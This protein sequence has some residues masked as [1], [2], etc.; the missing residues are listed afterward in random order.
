MKNN[1]SNFAFSKHLARPALALIAL[2][3]LNLGLAP[4]AFAGQACEEKPQTPL[5]MRNAFALAAQTRI[6]IP[7][8]EELVFI[9]RV[10]SDLSKYGLRFS[11]LGIAWR[12]N[13]KGSWLVTHL[14]NRCGTAESSLY[15]EGLANFFAD[16]MFAWESVVMLPE[17]PLQAEIVKILENETAMKLHHKRYNLLAY[18]FSTQY[19]NSNQWVL[20]VLAMANSK[21]VTDRSSAQAWLKTA[22]YLPTTLKID[23]LTRL[24]ARMTK[25]NVAF[26]DHPN[27]RRFADAI[28]VVSVESVFDFM[29]KKSMVGGVYPAKLDLAFTQGKAKPAPPPP[30]PL[31]ANNEAAATQLGVEPNTRKQTDEEL[32]RAAEF[33]RAMDERHALNEARGEVVTQ[34]RESIKN[35]DLVAGLDHLDKGK[36]FFTSAV[37]WQEILLLEW[38]MPLTRLCRQPD[39][40]PQTPPAPVCVQASRKLTDIMLATMQR[41]PKH[42]LTYAGTLI[43]ASTFSGDTAFYAKFARQAIDSVKKQMLTGDGFLEI[44]Q[45]QI[46]KIEPTQPDAVLGRWIL[47]KSPYSAR[48]LQVAKIRNEDLKRLQT[49]APASDAVVAYFQAN[50]PDSAMNAVLMKE[51]HSSGVGPAQ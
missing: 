41:F 46:P 24:G 17:R 40:T 47:E 2:L 23:A 16:D 34:W 14:L 25:A 39:G 30:D 1:Y 33:Q 19:Q 22:G 7:Q 48:R 8:D 5:R 3:A 37:Q 18:P 26:D 21:Q 50:F 12:E 29:Q 31:Q 42:Q 4:T 45:A 6:S 28:D 35:N 10:G 32:A 20:E 44:S 27:Q 51:V 11:H 9:A 49:F 43:S 13:P 38:V 15:T 36:A